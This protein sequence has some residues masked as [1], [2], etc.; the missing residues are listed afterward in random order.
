[1]DGVGQPNRVKDLSLA[2]REKA[3]HPYN[4]R[5]MVLKD[6]FLDQRM[7]AFPMKEMNGSKPLAEMVPGLIHSEAEVVGV[8]KMRILLQPLTSQRIRP[9]VT[10]C[11]RA[12]DRGL[13]EPHGL[14]ISVSF[15]EVTPRSR[16]QLEQVRRQ[17]LK[18]LRLTFKSF[19]N[20]R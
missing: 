9:K 1:M 4:L 18:K 8:E 16:R 13:D 19:D 11:L 17:I 14:Q 20:T 5:W 12:V 3:C 15:A 10:D 2:L 7:G 6:V